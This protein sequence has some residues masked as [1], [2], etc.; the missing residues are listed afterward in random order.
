MRVP[1]LKAHPSPQDWV[2]W[3]ALAK[4]SYMLENAAEFLSGTEN[5]DLPPEEAQADTG[6]RRSAVKRHKWALAAATIAMQKNP[7]LTNMI[8]DTETPQWP[9]GRMHLVYAQLKQEFSPV[10]D[11]GEVA[12]ED[13]LDSIPSLGK[14]ENNTTCIDM[15]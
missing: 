8:L 6:T 14:D 10:D 12:K 7:S 1:V 15:M 5:A 4:A 11:I 3:E 9:G 2:K 13:A